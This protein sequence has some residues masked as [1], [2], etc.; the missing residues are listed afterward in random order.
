MSLPAVLQTA[1]SSLSDPMP[2]ITAPTDDRDSDLPPTSLAIPVDVDLAPSAEAAETDDEKQRDS[3]P[4]I[5]S[6]EADDAD[7]DAILAEEDAVVPGTESTQPPA[8]PDEPVVP[9]SD[10]ADGGETSATIASR[11]TAHISDGEFNAARGKA[12][13]IP[14]ESGASA[15]VSHN[16]LVRADIITR[17]KRTRVTLPN[18]NVVPI[19]VLQNTAT[20]LLDGHWIGD[21]AALREVMI[22]TLAA[23]DPAAYAGKR[24]DLMNAPLEDLTHVF[25]LELRGKRVPIAVRLEANRPKKGAVP[26][27]LPP[28]P[29][30]LRS[31]T[32]GAT[33]PRPGKKR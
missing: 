27:P 22:L 14:P 31:E 33:P 30:S 19:D 17:L 13:S 15:G 5:T 4:M 2:T 29:S 23:L 24:K 11:D 25:L 18:P 32:R 21:E 9:A 26:P 1:P 7:I 6:D 28:T 12:A 8:N 3:I 10:P 16:D 20:V